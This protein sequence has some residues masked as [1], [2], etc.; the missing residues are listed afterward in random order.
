MR[1]TVLN[2]MLT[3]VALGIQVLPA[4]FTTETK[5]VVRGNQVALMKPLVVLVLEHMTSIHVHR[6]AVVRGQIILKI[7][8]ALMSPLAGQLEDVLLIVITATTIQMAVEMELLAE[9]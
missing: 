5:V 6:I 9:L 4:L 8:L 2:G 1:P 7:A 3:A